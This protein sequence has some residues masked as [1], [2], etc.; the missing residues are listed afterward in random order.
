MKQ[1]AVLPPSEVELWFLIGCG[2]APGA[3]GRWAM[4]LCVHCLGSI[5]FL[6]GN[7]YKA[8]FQTLLKCSSQ[9]SLLQPVSL[10]TKGTNL[11]HDKQKTDFEVFLPDGSS[12]S[13][14]VWFEVWN[15]REW[16]A[17][18]PSPE[19]WR[20]HVFHKGDS[21]KVERWESLNSQTQACSLSN[22]QSSVMSVILSQVLFGVGGGHS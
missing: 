20:K 14:F 8:H 19:T 6:Q 15:K 21:S 5:H 4:C 17:A 10:R 16:L 13:L 18:W 9:T 1:Q 7:F 2:E 11:G 22:H 3:R 12:M